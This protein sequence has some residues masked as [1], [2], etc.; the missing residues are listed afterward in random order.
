MP[1]VELSTRFERVGEP[2]ARQGGGPLRKRHRRSPYPRLPQGRGP[3]ASK[4][5]LMPEAP[6]ATPAP[7]LAANHATASLT[8]FTGRALTIFRAGFALKVV[9]SFVNGL[10]PWRAFVAGFLIT[11][12]LASPGTTNAPVFLSS[13]WPIAATASLTA[14]TAFRANSLVCPS[15]IRLR[16]AALVLALAI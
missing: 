6:A 2:P 14:L 11:M 1:V 12:N 15:I 7:Q 16:G 9:G 10:M 4:C 13:L 3:N 8:A 5:D